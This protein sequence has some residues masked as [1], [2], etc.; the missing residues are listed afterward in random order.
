MINDGFHEVTVFFKAVFVNG[1]SWTTDIRTGWMLLRDVFPG[2]QFWYSIQWTRRILK[3]FKL[4][5]IKHKL[6]SNH[7][8]K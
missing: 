1:C 3:I 6:V 8:K 7:K 4:F 5:L 2:H